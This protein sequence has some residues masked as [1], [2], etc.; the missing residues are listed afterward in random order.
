MFLNFVVSSS[1]SYFQK[2]LVSNCVHDQCS[3]GWFNFRTWKRRCKFYRLRNVQ[4]EV[5]KWRILE[6]QE[7]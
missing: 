5:Y 6:K 1:F 2:F 3:T 7:C 4:K